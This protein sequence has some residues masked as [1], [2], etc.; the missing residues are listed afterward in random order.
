MEKPL[1]KITYDAFQSNLGIEDFLYIKEFR[2]EISQDYTQFI[3]PT[4]TGRGG[5]AYE[6]ILEFFFNLN[7][8]DYIK[9]IGI[10]LL[11]KTKDRIVDPILEKY[12]FAPFIKAFSKFSEKSG[13]IDIH[14]FTIE[15]HD[16]KITIYKVSEENIT[17]SLNKILET[18]YE[19]FSDLVIDDELPSSFLIPAI[20]DKIRNDVIY[21]PPLG[22]SETLDNLGSS[23]YFKV[24]ALDYQYLAGRKLYSIEKKAFIE[25]SEFFT[26]SEFFDKLA[27][28]N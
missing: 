1:L 25:D 13:G 17:I 16:S 10:F 19:R 27:D 22:M 3:K 20:A 21:R 24:W 9:Y 8:Q 15:L 7:L 11:G 12:L 14:Q 2:D 4:P 26:E 18:I 23:D 6:L 5:G 28:L